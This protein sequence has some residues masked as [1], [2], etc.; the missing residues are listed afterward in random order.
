LRAWKSPQDTWQNEVKNS[1]PGIPIIIDF[2]AE[3][4]RDHPDSEALFNENAR[5]FAESATV[6]ARIAD[7]LIS[8]KVSALVNLSL[9]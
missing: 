1:N 3:G 4:T 8:I 5:Q 6:A 9:L 2:C 7:Q